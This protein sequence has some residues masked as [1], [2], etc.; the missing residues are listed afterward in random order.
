VL[1]CVNLSVLI[2]HCFNH[3][4][5]AVEKIFIITTEYIQYLRSF[6]K[7]VKVKKQTY[8]I[9]ISTAMFQEWQLGRDPGFTAVILGIW[10]AKIGRIA[11]PSHPRQKLDKTLSQQKKKTFMPVI[12]AAARGSWF[13]LAWAKAKPYLKI[14][15]SKKGWRYGSSGKSACLASVKP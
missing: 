15:K 1:V 8:N 3:N 11:V 13:W 5:Y 14:N 4:H 10:G 7:T 12:P 6:I 2:F 9:F